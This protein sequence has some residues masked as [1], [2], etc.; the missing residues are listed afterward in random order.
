[1][2]EAGL[3]LVLD[4]TRLAAVGMGTVFLFLT[5]LV[6]ATATM[7]R[8]VVQWL[9]PPPAAPPAAG[10]DQRHLVAVIAAAIHAHRSRQ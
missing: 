8:L 9:P 1:M 4:G 3:E 7:S 6:W 5:L 2:S 10:A